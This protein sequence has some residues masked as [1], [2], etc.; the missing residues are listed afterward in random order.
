MKN[1]FF[2]VAVACFIAGFSLSSFRLPPSAQRR[3]YWLFA[4][5]AGVSGYLMCYPDREKGFGVAGLFFAAMVVAAYT[6]TPYI[7][8]GD[9][10]FALSL[11]DSRLDD[12]EGTRSGSD[13]DPT[14]DSYN[15]ML[16]AATMW[17]MLVV[18]SVI[19]GGN[20]YY[21][22]VGREHGLVPWIM[23]AFLALLAIGVGYADGSWNYPIARRQHIQFAVASLVSAGSFAVLYLA[24]YYT[25]R[26]HPLRRQ[27]SLEYRAHPRHQQRRPPD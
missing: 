23:A 9:R 7:K 8:I 26:I 15:G 11:A 19:A 6:A 22:A 21:A 20:A 17:W 4:C 27:Q 24:S 1:I 10:V 14:P 2:G 5:L 25:A 12:P 16:S 13:I 18:I 3:I